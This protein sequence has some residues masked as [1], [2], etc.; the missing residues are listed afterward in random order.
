MTEHGLEGVLEDSLV[1]RT[2]EEEI[3]ADPELLEHYLEHDPEALAEAAE[4]SG[5]DCFRD[6]VLDCLL[7]GQYYELAYSI[8]CDPVIDRFAMDCPADAVVF[9]VLKRDS[10]LE[11]RARGYLQ[12]D[13]SSE[14]VL[15]AY[16]RLMSLGTGGQDAAHRLI[17]GLGEGLA[18]LEHFAE[19]HQHAIE[20]D[21]HYTMGVLAHALKYFN[22]EEALVLADESG[23]YDLECEL[24]EELD[25][26]DECLGAYSALLST[27]HWIVSAVAADFGVDLPQN[28]NVGGPK[29]SYATIFVRR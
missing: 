12:G 25:C 26:S 15:D 3:E 9:A 22:P 6:E 2:I 24:R 17:G 13:A 11:E 27:A 1:L 18:D 21:D 28:I 5:C 20:T 7:D 10:A 4:I 8:D 29:G 16:R 14:E 23:D 19:I